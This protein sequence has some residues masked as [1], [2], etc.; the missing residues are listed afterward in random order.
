MGMR[1]RAGCFTLIGFQ[2]SWAC[3]CSV[4]FPHGAVGWSAVRLI[5]FCGFSSRCR[6]LVCST[7]DTNLWLFLTVPWLGRQC[8]IVVFTD[9]THIFSEEG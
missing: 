8:V 5:L 4:A 1:E 7:V 6:R 3:Y 2:I 9:H